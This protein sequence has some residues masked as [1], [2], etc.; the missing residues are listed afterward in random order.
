MLQNGWGDKFASALRCGLEHDQSWAA[1]N[2]VGNFVGNFVGLACFP[3]PFD[4]ICDEVCLAVPNLNSSKR[5][6]QRISSLKL[7][8]FIFFSVPSVCSCSTYVSASR[9]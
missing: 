1:E 3:I 7:T 8:T 9:P 6:E 5:R 2:L 4:K